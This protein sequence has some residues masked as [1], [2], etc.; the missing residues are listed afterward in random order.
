M[1]KR[2]KIVIG[3]KNKK[4]KIRIH[5]NPKVPEQRT[6]APSKGF[7]AS[8][9]KQKVPLLVTILA[10]FSVLLF[11]FFNSKSTDPTTIDDALLL[12][13]D[14]PPYQDSSQYLFETTD[15]TTSIEAYL[16]D[17]KVNQNNINLIL[18]KT[19]ALGIKSFQRGHKLTAITPKALP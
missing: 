5:S 9:S 17:M 13:S 3:D 7:T 10:I 14:I 4:R 11:F 8:I 15:R 18:Q 12:D 6:P 1:A 2:K 19:N 16:E